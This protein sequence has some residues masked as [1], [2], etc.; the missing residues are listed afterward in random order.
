MLRVIITIVTAKSLRKEIDFID[1][2]TGKKLL[3]GIVEVRGEISDDPDIA[4][5]VNWLIPKGATEKTG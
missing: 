2:G 3:L 4:T 1:V 5:P